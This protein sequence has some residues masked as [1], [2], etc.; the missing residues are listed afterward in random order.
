MKKI[1]EMQENVTQKET[2]CQ[3]YLL[4]ITQ[5][6]SNVAILFNCPGGVA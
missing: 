5:L 6:F 1:D 2:F 3:K 4:K